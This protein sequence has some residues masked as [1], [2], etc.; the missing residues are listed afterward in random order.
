VGG[1]LGS[2]KYGTILSLE[3]GKALGFDVPSMMLT[4]ADEIIK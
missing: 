3:T 2:T 4:R 1:H